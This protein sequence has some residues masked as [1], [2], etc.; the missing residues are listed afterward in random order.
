MPQNTITTM[1]KPFPRSKVGTAK[2]YT[3]PWLTHPKTLGRVC[4]RNSLSNYLY[5]WA[6]ALFMPG[7][8][9]GFRSLLPLKIM[10]LLKKVV[11]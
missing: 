4:V 8:F 3:Q 7:T 2:D 11:V 5:L 10:V 6:V 9:Y 1:L